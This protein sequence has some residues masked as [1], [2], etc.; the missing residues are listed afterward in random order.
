MEA[1]KSSRSR[2]FRKDLPTSTEWAKSVYKAGNS[3][4]C[5]ARQAPFSPY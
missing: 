4:E 5:V 3:Q 2:G 1:P